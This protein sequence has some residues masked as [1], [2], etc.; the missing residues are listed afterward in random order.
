MRLGALLVAGVLCSAGPS[1]ALELVNDYPT[2]ARADYVFGCMKANGENSDS[3]RRCSCSI[4]V[5]ATIVPYQR[6]EE[7][8]TFMSLGQLSGENGALF[9]GAEESKAAIGDLKRAQAEAEM[10]CF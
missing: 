7:A 1:A 8:S 2:E 10:R 6:Y 4:D 5:I 3:L 9:R